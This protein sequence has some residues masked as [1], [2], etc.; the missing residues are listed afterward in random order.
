[1]ADHLA[2]GLRVALL[3]AAYLG[4]VAA[5]L[6]C[7]GCAMPL[8]ESCPTPLK[9]AC[10]VAFDGGQVRF[11]GTYYDFRAK[12][13]IQQIKMWV[14]P[15]PDPIRG[16]LFHGNPGGYGDTRNIPRDPQ[17]Q[18]FAARHGFAIIGVTSFP[19]GQVYNELARVV[20]AA[21]DDWAK[22]GFHP[23]IANLP[24]IAR[25]SSNAGVTAY[26]LACYVPERMICF[27]PNVGPRYTPP[28]PP[29]AA[30]K[31]PALLH[32]GTEDPF[33]R[34]GVERTRQLFA[35]ARPRGALW[36]WTAE[37]GKGHEIGHIDDIDMEFYDTCIALRLPPDADPRRGPVALREIPQDQ[38]WLADPASW[39]SGITHV[40]PWSDY[41]GDK[42]AACWL[43]TQDIA[44]LY[45]AVA[46]Y[47]NPLKVNVRDVAAV[48]NP[49]AS[50]V[51]LQSVG[52][53]VVEPGRRLVVECDAS[54]FADWT[55]LE[56]R[57]GARKLG[58]VKRGQVPRWELVVEPQRT[59]YAL[60][61]LGHDGAGRT[62]TSFPTHFLVRDPAVT[63]RLAAQREAREALPPRGPRP[64]WGSSAAREAPG[65]T[66]ASAHAADSVLV[67][68][69]LT[70][71]HES[72]FAVDGK[73]S[74]FWSAFGLEHDRVVLNVADHLV[75]PEDMGQ[76]TKPAGDVHVT[77][78][79]ARSRAGLYLLF[80]VED[81][82][83]VAPRGL[84]DSIDFHLAR[85]SSKDIW[86]G[87]PAAVF[88][89][90]ESWAMVLSGDQFQLNMGNAANPPTHVF[91]NYPDPWDIVRTEDDFATARERYGILVDI[92]PLLNGRRA[93]EW[94]IPWDYVGV[95]GQVS[96]PAT[97][98]R[99][100]LSLG[101]NDHDTGEHERDQFDRL[102][103]PNRVDPWGQA[104]D[105]GP[106]PSPWGDLEMG[107]P[108][109]AGG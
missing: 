56:L 102:R 23:E 52:G 104:G 22:L 109:A 91:R 17:L 31:V 93:V 30:L 69:A 105:K 79:A 2:E 99:L 82:D 71:E 15:G 100:G 20:I 3:Q 40:A 4:I 50:G 96:E 53:N 6:A 90:R 41:A 106:N 86:A 1:M 76:P 51:F 57:D 77:V 78:R 58:E 10:A 13:G 81:D 21:M 42:S 60:V 64:A 12:N 65:R 70:A 95:G 62:R 97:G 108:L 18:E 29:D 35:D 68:Y 74:P 38:G 14:P 48:E 39:K 87:D 88:V 101:Y 72:Q 19:G 33:F 45:R 11:D 9:P 80:G 8:H 85:L 54:G 16:A 25:G 27:T 103:W 55:R 84:E 46:T 32:V 94:F 36:A 107:P 73:M 75:Q 24:L 34:D 49:N 63:A 44:F 61:V 28:S 98:R 59:V 47:D 5:T 67:A 92:G 37:Q 83:F 89:K 66:D 43:P 26:S 7:A